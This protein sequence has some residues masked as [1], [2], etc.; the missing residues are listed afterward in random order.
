MGADS[1]P[2]WRAIARDKFP[3]FSIRGVGP[4]AV[5]DSTMMVVEL[6]SHLLNANCIGRKVIQLQPPTARPVLRRTIHIR[7]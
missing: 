1:Q 5:A 3:G 7:D 4:F 2:D 6:F